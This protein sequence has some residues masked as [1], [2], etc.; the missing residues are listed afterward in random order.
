MKRQQLNTALADI[1]LSCYPFGVGNN[2]EGV[3]ILLQIADYRI[4][5]DCG[6]QKTQ[7]IE[8]KYSLSDKLSI[9]CKPQSK[10]IR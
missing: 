2:T 3:A 5:L 9:S 4:L 6:L 7:S 1:N 8:V 10:R